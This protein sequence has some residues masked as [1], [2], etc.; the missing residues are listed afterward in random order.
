MQPMLVGVIYSQTF[1]LITKDSAHR[2]SMSCR[3]I[4]GVG[5]DR[6]QIVQRSSQGGKN[7]LP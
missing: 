5:Y 7:I 3:S 4:Q 1:S 2:T 6:Q